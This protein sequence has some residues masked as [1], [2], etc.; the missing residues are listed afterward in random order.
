MTQTQLADF[1]K[2]KRRITII[3]EIGKTLTSSLTV[4]DVVQQILYKES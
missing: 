1:E 3:H 4:K 2:I